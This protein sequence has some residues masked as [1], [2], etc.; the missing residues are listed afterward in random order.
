MTHGAETRRCGTHHGV[1][2]NAENGK[3]DDNANYDINGWFDELFPE[4]VNISGLFVQQVFRL[5]ANRQRLA[6]CLP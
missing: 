3:G 5:Q 6:W 1:V 4:F 2:S